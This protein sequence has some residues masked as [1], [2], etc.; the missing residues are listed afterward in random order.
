MYK[1]KS[2]ALKLIR[3]KET[4]S[5]ITYEFISSRTGYSKRQLIRL[6]KSLKKEKDM[7]S[8]LQHGN[9]GKEPV[10]KASLSEIN[11]FIGLKDK[12]PKITISQFR[13]IFIEDVLMNPEMNDVVIKYDLKSR[14]LSWFRNLFKSQNWKSPESRKPLRR[15]GRSVHPLRQP[16]A[17]RGRLVQ[18]DGT[19]YD[20]FGN[21]EMWTLHLAV[22]DA[23]SEVLAGYFM[24]TERQL[25]YCYMMKILLRKY[26]IPM[27]LYSDK[28]TIFKSIKDDSLSQFGMM[29]EDLGIE[30]IFANTAQAKGRIERYNGTVQRRL[31]NDIIRF[32]IKDYEEL[33]VWFNTFYIQYINKKFSF[34]PLDPIDAFVPIDDYD[35]SQV[36]TLRQDRTIK[37]DMFILD[38]KYYSII[39]E[40]G[41][42]IHII[43]G[44]KIDV[45]IDVFTNKITVN[46]YGK[47]YE[48]ILVSDRKR[49][50]NT[51]INN[52]KELQEFLNKEKAT[53]HS[54]KKNVSSH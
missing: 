46:R 36:F 9:V 33:N 29:M 41:S 1:N 15:D 50:A 42:K 23:T 22:D 18:I 8:L 47:T 38:H 2:L 12:Y 17:Q 20:W 6:S 54:L 24:P 28:H 51:V 27:S 10:N 34:I 52:Q 3:D 40:S 4:N 13:D 37:N 16:S 49:E 7:S 5:S 45:R 11:F 48:V 25:G 14:S 35:L 21:G 43:N 44:T 19:P 26:G 39:D 31:P 53:T 32:G 30:F